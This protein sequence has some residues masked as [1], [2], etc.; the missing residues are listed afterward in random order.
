MI[1]NEITDMFLGQ[2]TSSAA[3]L[4]YSNKKAVHFRKKRECGIN[5]IIFNIL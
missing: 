5:F 2:T 1:Q 3:K 4:N